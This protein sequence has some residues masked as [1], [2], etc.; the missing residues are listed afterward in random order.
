MT[1][2]ILTL[3]A[4]TGGYEMAPFNALRHGVPSR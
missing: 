3:P 2:T 4:R 1:E